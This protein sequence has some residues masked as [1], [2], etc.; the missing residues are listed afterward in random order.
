MGDRARYS[1][2]REQ[3]DQRLDVLEE[4]EVLS[5]LIGG[6]V[7]R[8]ANDKIARLWVGGLNFDW[9]LLWPAEKPVRLHLPAYP[10]AKERHWFESGRK[11]FETRATATTYFR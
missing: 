11:S 9:G 4:E 2:K 10:F 3:G 8:G 7:A 5:G 1:G 6:L